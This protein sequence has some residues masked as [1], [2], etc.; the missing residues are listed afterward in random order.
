MIFDEYIKQK[1]KLINNQIVDIVTGDDFEFSNFIK[2]IN[3]VSDKDLYNYISMNYTYILGELFGVKKDS[4]VDLLL[5]PKFLLV[6]N[7]ALA[8]K[9]FSNVDLIHLND[10]IYNN[11][12]FQNKDP[13]IRSILFSLGETINR[14]TVSALNVLGS[15]DHELCVFIAVTY[16]SSFKDTVNAKR[17]NLALCISSKKILSVNEIINIYY[18]LYSKMFTPLFIAT[19]FD[20]NVQDAEEKGEEWVTDREATIN[21]NITSAIM[22]LLESMNPADISRVLKVFYDEFTNTYK[23]NPN[24]IRTSIRAVCS[25][26]SRYVKIPI[27]IQELEGHNIMIP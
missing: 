7:Q 22:Y 17:I 15:L 2:N 20:R 25:E 21:D 24:A 8:D 13:F 23:S 4:Y 11:I 10:F 19:M 27:L 26:D 6:L 16:K 18:V 14:S 5:N 9:Q 3:T 1:P 12:V